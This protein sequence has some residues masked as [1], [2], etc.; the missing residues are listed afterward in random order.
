MIFYTL[1]FISQD[2]ISKNLHLITFVVNSAYVFLVI[3]RK[4]SLF[5]V[6]TNKLYD[7]IIF[8]RSG[9]LL[10]SYNFQTDKAVDDSLLKGSILIGINHILA[11]FSNIESQLSLIKL[12]D[13]GVVFN[14]N[15]DLG[16]AILVIAKHKNKILETAVNEFMKRFSEVNRINL[17]NLK[18]LIDVS[19]FKE[20]NE[21]IKDVFK[22]YI[23][24]VLF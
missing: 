18:G 14:F 2:F 11:N 17:K 8:H 7:F 3:I 21:I 24:K 5:L 10:Y 9:I 12:S 20:T 15:N 1:Y 16:Y 13:R 23:P 6:F 19:V 4:P 22:H